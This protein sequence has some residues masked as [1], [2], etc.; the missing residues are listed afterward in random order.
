MKFDRFSFGLIALTLSGW[1]DLPA[2]AQQVNDEAK[3]GP[4]GMVWIPS[5][6]FS[7]GAVVNGH[8]KAWDEAVAKGWTVVGMKDDW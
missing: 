8:G 1:S 5:G 6:K 7:M 2:L 3:A 4:R